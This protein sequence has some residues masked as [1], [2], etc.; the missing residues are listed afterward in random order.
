LKHDI[1]TPD[2]EEGLSTFISLNEKN[3]PTQ[4]DHSAGERYVAINAAF[5]WDNL[6]SIHTDINDMLNNLVLD[7][8][9]TASLVGDFEEQQQATTDLVVIFLTSLFLV[10][11]VMAIQFNSLQHPIII[12]FIIPVTLTGVLIGLFLTQKELN[13]LSAIGV[14]ML[15]GIVI[16]NGILLIDRTKQL[17]NQDMD[18]GDAIID[19]G[20]ERI[21]H[22]VMTTL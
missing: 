11:V 3:I 14:I 6:A 2:G 7:R 15:I 1:V 22:I 4:I 5:V 8:G 18:K 19:S 16:N 9:Y 12:L 20:T 10:F 21:R 13:V 17:R